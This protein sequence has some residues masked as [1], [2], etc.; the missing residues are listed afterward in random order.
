MLESEAA[1]PEEGRAEMWAI[2]F[3]F[4]RIITGSACITEAEAWRIALGW[5]C[6]EEEDIARFKSRGAY[7]TKATLTWQ[8]PPAS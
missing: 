1:S 2:I 6:Q 8:K 5:P 3:P 7:A 4:G